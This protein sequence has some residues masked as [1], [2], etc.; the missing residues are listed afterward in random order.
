MAQDFSQVVQQ[1]Q[2]A[3]RRLETLERLQKEQGTAK[4]IILQAAPEV[5][6]EIAVAK[7]REKFDKS[8]GITQTDDAVRDNTEK[9]SQEIDKLSKVT[10]QSATA[11]QQ[12][13]ETTDTLINQVEQNFE[14]D[15]EAFK[16]LDQTQQEFLVAT[17]VD[18]RRDIEALLE[19]RKAIKDQ[20]RDDMATAGKNEKREKRES[21][22]LKKVN[23]EILSIQK[24][25]P[26]IS[27]SRRKEIQK[28]EK[29]LQGSALKNAFS[30]FTGKQDSLFKKFFGAKIPFLPGLTVG[31]LAGLVAIPLLIKFLRSK[32]FEDFIDFI[33]DFDFKDLF[34]T[35]KNVFKKIGSALGFIA[36]GFKDLYKLITLDFTDEE[37]NEVGA[38]KFLKDNFGELAFAISV[39]AAAFTVTNIM[40]G[41][42][43]GGIFG[44]IPFIK[45]GKFNGAVG[46]A[47]RG[48]FTL[49][50]GTLTT[51]FGLMRTL[52]TLLGIGGVGAAA[53]AASVASFGGQR[54]AVYSL[55][56]A[57]G[58]SRQFV[59]DDKGI[60]RDLKGKA[61]TVSQT[62]KLQRGIQSGS[63][64]PQ[65]ITQ[66]MSSA[67]F[68]KY[69]NIAKLARVPIIGPLVSSGL[70]GMIALNDE[71][72]EREK[73][74]QIAGIIG[75]NVGTIGMMAAGAA[76]FGTGGTGILPGLGTLAGILVGG[77]LGYFAGGIVGGAIA[78]FILGGVGGTPMT[79]QEIQEKFPQAGGLDVAPGTNPFLDQ[80]LGIGPNNMLIKPENMSFDSNNVGG[81]ID[82]AAFIRNAS[83]TGGGGGTNVTQLVSQDSGNI[84][85][86]SYTNVIRPSTQHNAVL[87][88]LLNTNPSNPTVMA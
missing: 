15:F 6:A 57:G 29:A 8:T 11:T 86:N 34:T 60:F 63:I 14:K 85:Q 26:F 19:T 73:A 30:I 78:D 81:F 49:L 83:M 69:P 13:S 12:S 17:E 1:L 2:L 7:G 16:K 33:A 40:G 59:L 5:A 39:M 3:N 24:K 41:M 61:A 27:E 87:Q 44:G 76:I 66:Q 9:L 71:L 67:L 58:G 50:G 64:R 52:P 4:G 68:R 18:R 80:G 48:V 25:N 43:L 10:T 79:Q 46:I 77:G 51:L 31:R 28:E 53:V 36:D 82:A 74:K 62:Q 45:G 88:N 56:T 84:E 38:L 20:A 32:A 47:I 75:A 22:E 42:I 55:P 72:S 21:E 37:G 65:G 35:I 23:L 70:I 54:G